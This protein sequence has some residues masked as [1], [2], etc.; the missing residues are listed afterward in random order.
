MTVQFDINNLT[1]EQKASYFDMM[2]RRGK[3]D[4]AYLLSDFSNTLSRVMQEKLT[5]LKEPVWDHEGRPASSI[6]AA[7]SALDYDCRLH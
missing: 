5:D 3:I 2:M 6:T 1:I 7:F 4:P